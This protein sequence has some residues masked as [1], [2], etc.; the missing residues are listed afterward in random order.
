MMKDD[1]SPLVARINKMIKVIRQNL[2]DPD[3]EKHLMENPHV[4][5]QR[6]IILALSF[7]E[8]LDLSDC[9][10]LFK[11]TYTDSWQPICYCG[12]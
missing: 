8:E 4:V 12:I 5:S 2:P 7:F 11:C 1:V 9:K 10:F 3:K 6:N